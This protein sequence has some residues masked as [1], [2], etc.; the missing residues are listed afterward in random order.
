MRGGDGSRVRL[1]VNVLM[2]NQNS[3]ARGNNPRT[4]LNEA[5]P[6][7]SAMSEPSFDPK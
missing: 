7:G 1:T 5:A 2:I 4:G 3:G 6:A